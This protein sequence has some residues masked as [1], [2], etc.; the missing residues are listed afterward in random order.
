MQTKDSRIPNK[1]DA[2]NHNTELNVSQYVHFWFQNSKVQH[3][4]FY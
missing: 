1:I 4:K 2:R 3:A